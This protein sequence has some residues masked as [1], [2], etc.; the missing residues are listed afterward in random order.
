MG[1]PIESSLVAGGLCGVAGMLPDLDSDTGIPIRESMGFAAGIVPVL[2]IDR[3]HS[4]G[5]PYDRMVLVAAAMYFLIRFAGGS[6]LGRF[7]VH[8][9]MFHSIPAAL[10]FAGVAFLICGPANDEYVRYLKAGG[11]FFGVMSHLFL[12]ELYSVEWKGGNWRL[13]RSSGTA[14][15][16]WGKNGWAN[17][18]CYAKLAV[19]GTMVAGESSVMN[20]LEERY[21]ELAGKVQ[22]IHHAQEQLL[23]DV[24]ERVTAGNDAF[25][26]PQSPP[27]T[28]APAAGQPQ[29]SG[30][31]AWP[32]APPSYPAPA[33]APAPWQPNPPPPNASPDGFSPNAGARPVYRA[34]TNAFAPR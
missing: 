28:H 34:D 33:P 24:R 2:L 30:F 27:G 25:V 32:S 6:L 16:L 3:F 10:T 20:Y 15:K 23:T 21:P 7:S 12:D 5:L 31:P 29:P 4:L 13:K 1:F 9:G 14:V 19:V 8:R 17:F 18:S 22:R 11:V 26:V